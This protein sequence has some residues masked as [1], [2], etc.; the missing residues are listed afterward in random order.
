MSICWYKN[1]CARFDAVLKKKRVPSVNRSVIKGKGGPSPKFPRFKSSQALIFYAKPL[2]YI[3]YHKYNF[4]ILWYF[5]KTIF[6]KRKNYKYLTGKYL[7]TFF[8]A[9]GVAKTFEKN[10]REQTLKKWKKECLQSVIFTKCAHKSLN[11]I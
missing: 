7:L 1:I 2:L 3:T 10:K 8:L 6:E 4:T 5:G 11:L 9:H